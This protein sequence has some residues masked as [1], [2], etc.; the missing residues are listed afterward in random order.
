[1]FQVLMYYFLC[2]SRSASL[3]QTVKVSDQVEQKLW[4]RETD[5]SSCLEMAAGG[6]TAFEMRSIS[7]VPDL[8]CSKQGIE[9]NSLRYKLITWKFFGVW[10]VLLNWL[11]SELLSMHCVWTCSIFQ[12][13]VFCDLSNPLHA[14]YLF[15]KVQK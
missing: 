2:W 10:Y 1:M 7:M 4:Q 13:N 14:K 8:N 5:F 3:Y 6:M 12:I 11:R 15:C 9:Q